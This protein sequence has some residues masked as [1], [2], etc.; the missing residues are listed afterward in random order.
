MEVHIEIFT[1]EMKSHM[2]LAL[3]QCREGEKR[4]GRDEMRLARC[5]PLKLGDGDM[6]FQYI[7]FLYVFENLCNKKGGEEA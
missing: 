7:L 4:R 1:A 3:K 6:E 2:E 5:G